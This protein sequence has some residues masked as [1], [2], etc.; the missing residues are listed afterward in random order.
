MTAPAMTATL[1]PLMTAR[2]ALPSD[3]PACLPPLL[4][5]HATGQR[6][7]PQTRGIGGRASGLR[8]F[9]RLT[10]RAF[11]LSFH[12]SWADSNRPGDSPETGNEQVS[13]Y[14]DPSNGKHHTHDDERLPEYVR[15]PIAEP[16]QNQPEKTDREAEPKPAPFRPCVA[17]I[18]VRDNRGKRTHSFG[19]VSPH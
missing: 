19:E 3:C 8:W 15:A 1:V 9:A 7:P 16:D 6:P 2:Y 5:P 14:R 18:P 11:R 17:M 13:Q 12:C 10:P 4:C